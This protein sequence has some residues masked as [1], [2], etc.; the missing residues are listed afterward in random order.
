MNVGNLLNSKWGIAKN[1]A[2][3]NSG[4]ILK[5]EGKDENNVPTFS[6]W[7]DADG[8]APTE[9]W[10]YIKAYSQ[11]WKLQLGIRYTFN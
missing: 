4:K 5:Y 3:C 11:C 9:T 1:M 8:N 10:S 7:R 6:M 2:N